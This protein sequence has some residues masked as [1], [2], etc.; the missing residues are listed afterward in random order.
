MYDRYL[1]IYFRRLRHARTDGTPKFHRSPSDNFFVV[2]EGSRYGDI[3]P[4]HV[5]VLLSRTS[6]PRLPNS[7]VIHPR[8]RHFIAPVDRSLTATSPDDVLLTSSN[9]G[10]HADVI[11]K[12]RQITIKPYFTIFCEFHYFSE[13]STAPPSACTPRRLRHQPPCDHLQSSDS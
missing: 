2:Q 10:P 4:V 9:P 6:P 5:P 7:S 8:G 11:Q 12:A 3:C 1:P 13:K